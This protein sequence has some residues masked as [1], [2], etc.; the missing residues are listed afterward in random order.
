MQPSKP[1]FEDE[2]G[3]S[4][5]LLEPG[6]FTIGDQNGSG[7]P[8][9]QPCTEVTLSEP[10]FLAARPVTQIQWSTRMGSNPSKFQDGWSAGLR[11]IESISFVQ[12]QHFLEVLNTEPSYCNWKGRRLPTEAEWEYAAYADTA[13][14]WSFGDKDSELDAHGWH[15][16]N[17]GAT[18]REVGSKKANQ[19]GF[20]D[21]HGMIHEMTYDHWN[22]NHSNHPGSQAPRENSNHVH[23]GGSWFTES[24]SS[25][26][27]SRR[28]FNIHE[29]RDGIGLRLVWEPTEK[30]E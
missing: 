8:N 10:I 17:S 13:T 24:D 22:K 1:F 29:G 25:R 23:R 28:K 20:Y 30:V 12:V 9:E 2:F 5:L 4:Y 11:P 21:M 7:H 26:S 15:A 18:T 14:R 6:S 3:G 16:G 19:W 27:S